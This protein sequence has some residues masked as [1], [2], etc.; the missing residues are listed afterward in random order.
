MFKHSLLLAY[1]NFKK[2]KSSFFINLIGLSTG[3]AC[4]LLIYLWV[5][6]ELGFDKFHENDSQLYQ[7]MTQLSFS[8][9]IITS[10]STQGLL[11]EALVDEMPEVEYAATVIPTHWNSNITLSVDDKDIRAGGQYV[12]KDY[13]KIFSFPLIQGDKDQVL[14]D[15]NAMVI[16]EEL[17]NKI[18]NTSEN[19]IGRSVKFQHKKDYFISGVF[20]NI[21][22][23]SS[24]Q[25]DFILSYEEF[26]EENPWV[27]GWGVNA[28]QTYL[29]LKEG[30]NPDQFNGKIK[31][32]LDNK[33]DDPNDSHRSLLARPFSENYLYGRYENGKQAGGRIAYVRL[34]SIVAIFI[35]FIACINFM[36]LSTAKAFRRLK[37]V[38]IKKA[39]GA[40]RTTLIFQYLGE[41]MLMTLLALI[42]AIIM[43]VLFLPEF[44]E[45]TAKQLS[46]VFDAKLI[47]SVLGITLL[48]GLL[49]GSY[50]ALYLSGFNPAT[51]LKGG[52]AA[53]KISAT[54]GELWAR[55]GLVVFQFTLSI[56]LIVAVL[57][58]YK[59]IEF[60]QTKNIGFDKDN[61]LYFEMEGPIEEK[62][63]TYLSEIKN[64]P[65]ILDASG[66]S[67]TFMGQ[68]F[69]VGLDW[70]EGKNPNEKIDFERVDVS[71]GLMGVLDIKMAAGRSFSRN[72]GADSTKIIFNEAA[73]KAMGL[74][75]PVGKVVKLWE[76]ERQI[77]GVSG[78]LHF[79]SL[80]EKVK[81][82]FFCLSAERTR[83]VMAK[84]EAGKEKEAIAS[85][86]E[87]YQGFNPGFPFE[88]KFLDEDYQAQ[89][90]AEQRV[91]SLSQYFAGFTILISCLGL[92][93]LAAFAAEQRRKEIG[94][95]KVLGA[96]VANLMGLLS[97][98]FIQLVSI[99][100]VV[101]S[102]L[103]WIA[104]TKWLESFA[105]RIELGWWVFG[106]AGA[107]ALLIAVA[108]VSYQAVKAATANPVK[109]LRTE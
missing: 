58:V 63:E 67:H 69:S 40:N 49:S 93:G 50:P 101:G 22:E 103:S 46:L 21:P 61:I 29:V 5:N 32:F 34:F 39:V 13:F 3:L 19:I 43:V 30:T 73:I 4:T 48:T 25:F 51:I 102:L 66:A 60:V 6:D 77:I 95:R 70:W 106:V 80:H 54:V 82:M 42:L 33:S 81:P 28:P 88:F 41:S 8:G 36:N 57:V 87:H 10:M 74:S 71:Y 84:V 20:K 62:R 55:K 85:L 68:Q 107:A 94:I 16:S 72:Y 100:I 96:S 65:G 18:F 23:N 104:M 91:A 47:L 17:A 35:L 53:S 2:F 44:N 76:E 15:K 27:L 24:L 79:Q 99:A 59:Q 26:K 108:T 97:K 37:E 105:Y 12:G 98:D 31:N 1:R 109:N 78:D 56:I 11:A 92:Y 14:G 90:E 52:A 64:L 45:I 7:V 89:Y 83:W 75:D 38:G 86:E 9:E